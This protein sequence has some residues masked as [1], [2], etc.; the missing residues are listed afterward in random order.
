MTAQIDV[1]SF[2]RGAGRLQLAVGACLPK[3]LAGGINLTTKT[4]LSD[5]VC[6]RQEFSEGWEGVSEEGVLAAHHRKIRWISF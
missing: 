1:L 2:A 4:H 3:Y 6:R 5:M